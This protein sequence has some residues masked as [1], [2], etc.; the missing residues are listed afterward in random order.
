MGYMIPIRPRNTPECARHRPVAGIQL[1]QPQPDSDGQGGPAWG[2]S[3]TTS[4]GAPG[5]D[6]TSNFA[7]VNSFDEQFPRTR[8]HTLCLHFPAVI[9]VPST[10]YAIHP[11]HGFRRTTLIAATEG[12]NRA[13]FWFDPS[14]SSAAIQ[15]SRA[16]RRI[17]RTA[18]PAQRGPPEPNRR[19][20]CRRAASILDKHSREYHQTTGWSA[21]ELTPQTP[22]LAMTVPDGM[23]TDMGDS[24][25]PFEGRPAGQ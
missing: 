23:G 22:C 7:G 9:D 24:N 18:S 5:I 21:T 1:R 10:G 17:V 14:G 3:F 20:S 15:W 13:A 2:V 25:G 6:V 8:F 12:F 4:T 16:R 11:K 19:Q